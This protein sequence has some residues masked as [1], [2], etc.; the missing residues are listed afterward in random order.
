MRRKRG[1]RLSAGTAPGC[2]EPPEEEERLVLR[3]RR[4][5]T[6]GAACSRT[7]GCWQGR[8]AA[9]GG[10]ATAHGS[11][12][13]PVWAS[14]EAGNRKTRHGH[15][16]RSTREDSTGPGT[17]VSP[18]SGRKAWACKPCLQPDRTPGPSSPVP[19]N[20]RATLQSLPDPQ[21]HSVYHR[22]RVVGGE[23]SP[24][25]RAAGGGKAGSAGCTRAIFY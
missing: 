14:Q 12:R 21:N 8:R 1:P 25:P 22:V 2:P 4:V 16:H 11:R 20:A 19:G 3:R 15:P 13:R 23:V 9:G 7:A 24:L 10:R 5:D 6:E 17:A 18:P